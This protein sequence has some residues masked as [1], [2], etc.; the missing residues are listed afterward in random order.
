VMRPNRGAGPE[1][2]IDTTVS[3][4][5]SHAPLAQRQSNGLLIRRFRVQIPRGAPDGTGC[6]RDVRHLARPTNWAGN[7]VFGAV[8]LHKPESVDDL[9]RIVHGSRRI[10]AIGRGHSFSKVADT[11]GELVL[12]DAL[13][14]TFEIDRANSTVTVASRTTYAELALE[15]DVA[16]FA[17]ANMASIPNISLAGAS[18]T[19]THG[20]GDDQGVLATSVAAIQLVLADGELVE[21]RR[22]VDQDTFRG[23]VVALGALGIVTHLTLDIEPAYEMS[24][25]V[26]VGVPL[27]ELERRFDEVFRAGYS[28]SAFTDWHSGTA[29]VWVK[30]RM[31]LPRSNW[32]VGRP[33]LDRFHPIPGISPELCTEQSGVVGP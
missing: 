21:L 22:D 12:L 27:A 17:L 13:P 28:V 31:D 19:G 15:L 8:R 9:R 1:G 4:T 11:A 5:L 10:R 33:S 23:S 16:G 26:N 3:P 6:P 30:R 25:Q 32:S 20:S 14:K 2:R 18:A 24:Q 29:S 7:V